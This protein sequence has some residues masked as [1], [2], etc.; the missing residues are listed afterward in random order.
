MILFHFKTL[1]SCFC[2]FSVLFQSPSWNWN[3]TLISFAGQNV[4]LNILSVF[5][6]QLL[7]YYEGNNRQYNADFEFYTN[8]DNHDKGKVALPN[9]K[10]FWKSLKRGGGSFSIQKFILQI[11]GT[12]KRA[13][14]SWNWY[15]I[16]ILGL[17]VFFQQ[18]YWEK[19]K[20]DTLF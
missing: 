19:S 2:Y 5:C 12:L 17:R 1:I 6:P 20:Q 13:F 4:H 3:I 11:L 15:K 9:R 10:N 7:G 14:W 18:L 8:D 16:V